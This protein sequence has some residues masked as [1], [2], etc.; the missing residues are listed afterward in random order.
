MSCL[1]LSVTS[2]TTA[3]ITSSSWAR[4][5][6]HRARNAENGLSVTTPGPP[7]PPIAVFTRAPSKSRNRVCTGRLPCSGGRNASIVMSYAPAPLAT[8]T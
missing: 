6:P 3:S 5:R 8:P 4:V 7:Q 1:R 2:A